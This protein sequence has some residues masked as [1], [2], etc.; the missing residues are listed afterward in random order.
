MFKSF[1]NLWRQAIPD[2]L[3][4]ATIPYI[5]YFNASDDFTLKWA[6]AISESPSAT[7][8]MSTLSD[9][10]EGYGFKDASLEE[11]KVNQKGETL[12]Q[13]HQKTCREYAQNE[14]FFWL[15][16]YNALGKITHW[17]VLPFENCRLGK[18]DDNGYISKIYYNPFFGTQHYRSINKHTKCYDAF[19]LLNV[20]QQM[21]EQGNKYKGQVYYFGTTNSLTRFYP[22]NE[23]YAAVKWMKVEAGVSNYHEDNINNG[24]LHPFMLVMKGN[25][26]DP[27]NNPQ[28]N[29]DI[30]PEH[31]KITKAQ[32]FD[33]IVGANFMGA[34]R[35]GNM[36]VQWVNNNEEKPEILNFPTNGNGDVF[37]TLDN[38]AIKKI[39]VAWKVPAILANIQEGVS[40]GGDGNQIRVAVKLMQQRVIKRQRHLT[41]AYSDVLKNFFE[42]YMQ[43]VHIVPYNPYPEL[44]VLDDKI[45]AAMTPEEQRNWIQENTEVDLQET[46]TPVLLPNQSP[47]PVVKNAIPVGFPESVKKHIKDT[48]EYHNEM[49][50]SC[51]GKGSMEVSNMIVNGQSIPYKQLKRIH[52]YLN[53][54]QELAN[55]PNSEGCDVV[56]YNLWGGKVMYDFLNTKMKE[57]DSW[58]N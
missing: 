16:R 8:C 36:F 57:V 1:K 43:E 4:G 9:F 56:K 22:I 49:G 17:E 11:K 50:L 42:P 40:L 48:I 37:V 15:L 18:P 47:A 30:R 54:R 55:R 28:Y 24:F 41:D 58:L 35:I 45:W 5:E 26:N 19:N 23:A 13:I 3:K 38:Q 44:E 12:W 33:E 25:P 32:E 7:A 20:K 53:D 6:K 21:I 39:T 46:D 29:N 51:A 14:G 52:K 31:E 10:L 34:D 27:S 2:Y